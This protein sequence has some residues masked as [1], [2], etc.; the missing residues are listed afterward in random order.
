[1]VE[2]SSSQTTNC[3]PV[4]MLCNTNKMHK[5]VLYVCMYEFNV[6]KEYNRNIFTFVLVYSLRSLN[7]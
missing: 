4:R 3:L 7:P 6:V 5:N 1:M 2:D